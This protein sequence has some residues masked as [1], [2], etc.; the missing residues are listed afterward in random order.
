MVEVTIA[1]SG[2]G[3]GLAGPTT[4]CHKLPTYFTYLYLQQQVQ[5]LGRAYLPVVPS[6]PSLPA[7]AYLPTSTLPTYL[8]SSTFYMLT[9]EC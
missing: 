7:H 4:T 2:L 6:S 8:H 1:L 5:G 9:T 3:L